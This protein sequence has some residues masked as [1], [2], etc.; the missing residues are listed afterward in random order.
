VGTASTEAA[1]VL[2]VTVWPQAIGRA[3]VQT[4]LGIAGA[5]VRVMVKLPEAVP[6]P[7]T[8]IR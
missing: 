5:Q 1:E 2:P 4:S 8:S 7:V 3:P 6:K